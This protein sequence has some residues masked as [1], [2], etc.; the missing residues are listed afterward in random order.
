[1][2]SLTLIIP[3]HNRQNYLPRSISY[4]S[5]VDFSVVYCDSTVDAYDFKGADNIRY[6]H[7]PDFTF[8]QKILHVLEKINTSFVALC[9][10]DD[11]V[12]TSSLTSGYELMNEN[13]N[14]TTVIGNIIQFHEKFDDTFFSTKIYDSTNFNSPPTKNVEVFLSN[15]RQVLWGIY[16]IEILLASFNILNKA[17]FNNDNFFE[18]VI[19][20]LSAYN[21]EINFLKKEWSARE[22]STLNHWATRHQSLFY[23][24]TSKSIQDDIKNFIVLIDMNTEPGIGRLAINAYLKCSNFIKIKFLIKGFIKKYLKTN[25]I[26]ILPKN[27]APNYFN[28][29]TKNNK[30]FIEI[31]TLLNKYKDV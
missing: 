15:Y 7:L 25:F 14:V 27:I 1:M 9:A 5:N 12:F 3:T 20:V 18:L 29:D 22:L 10:D 30:D 24:M 8:S 28:F 11:F 2:K 26:K 31:A 16:K 4:Y 6:L 13:S 23:Y 21:G 19:S 17:K